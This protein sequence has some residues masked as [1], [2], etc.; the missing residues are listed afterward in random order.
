MLCVGCDSV[1]R[2]LTHRTGRRRPSADLGANRGNYLRLLEIRGAQIRNTDDKH[3]PNRSVRGR[4]PQ[5]YWSA[6][7]TFVPADHSRAQMA[8][9]GQ[10]QMAAD[11]PFRLAPGATPRVAD[12]TRRSQMWTV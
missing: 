9:S 10:K 2:Y 1:T 4:A 7:I 3:A 11:I 6:T 8:A 12:H 5:K